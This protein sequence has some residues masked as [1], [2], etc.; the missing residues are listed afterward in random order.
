MRFGSKEVIGLGVSMEKGGS[1]IDMGKALQTTVTRMKSELPVG[2]ELQ[3]VSNQPEAVSARGRIR[4]YPDRSH[5]HR[6]GRQLRRAGPAHQAA[7]HRRAAG[8]V[9]ALTIPLAAVTFLC[10]RL[11][12]IDCTRFR[13]AP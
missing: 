3:R 5:S 4:A 9:V 10:M 1:I 8:L 2:I 13:W 6:A 11:L 12:D 7:A